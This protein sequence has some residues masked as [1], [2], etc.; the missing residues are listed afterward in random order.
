MDT[1]FFIFPQKL[2]PFFNSG[3]GGR[4]AGGVGVGG[5]GAIE[6]SGA[7]RPPAGGSTPRTPDGS[8]APDPGPHPPAAR[9]DRR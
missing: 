8:A 2:K 9:P 5:G 3:V 4:R 1:G 6:G 7:L